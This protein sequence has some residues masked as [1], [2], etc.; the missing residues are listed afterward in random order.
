M[1]PFLIFSLR[2][3][4]PPYIQLS[5]PPPILYNLH[6]NKNELFMEIVVFYMP[7]STEIVVKLR[8]S[9]YA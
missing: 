2:D 1:G 3:V 5:T 7:M 6:F 8:I 9:C 4:I